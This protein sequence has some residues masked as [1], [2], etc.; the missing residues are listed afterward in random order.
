MTKERDIY[1]PPPAP[2]AFE[3]P[4][5][6]PLDWSRA[7][8]SVLLAFGLAVGVA[9]VLAWRTQPLLA[10]LTLVGGALVVLE[11]WYTAL[12]FL[13]RQTREQPDVS[14]MAIYLAALLP[15]MISLGLATAIMMAVFLLSDW[16]S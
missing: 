3:P 10:V 16:S 14:R 15:W 7:D 2:L 9:A 12:G 5:A 11:S 13:Q 8:L 1:N 6:E 4:V